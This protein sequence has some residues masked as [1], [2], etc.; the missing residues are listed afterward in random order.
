VD[1][2]SGWAGSSGHVREDFGAEEVEIHDRR[3]SDCWLRLFLLE[4]RLS[5]IQFVGR[6]LPRQL[7]RLLGVMRSRVRLGELRAIQEI[8]LAAGAACRPLGGLPGV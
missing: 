7:G 4:D 5:G 6:S 1:M 3:T 8:S 2:L